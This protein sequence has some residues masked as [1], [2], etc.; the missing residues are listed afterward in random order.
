MHKKLFAVCLVAVIFVLVWSLSPVFAK[1]PDNNGQAGKEIPEQEGTYDVSG[2]PNLK[3][4]VFIH[5]PARGGRKPTPTPTPTPPP[6][7]STIC[8]LSDPDSTF[9]VGSTGWHLASG[10]WIYNL[11]PNSVPASV[12]PANLTTISTAAFNRWSGAIGNKVTFVQG[13]NTTINRAVYDGKN[14]ITW[15]RVSNSALAITYT[16]YYPS[17]GLVAEVDTIMNS[18][19]LWSWSNPASWTD[20]STTC[21]V[22]DSYDAQDILTHELGHWVGLDDY[23]TDPYINNTMY[24]YGSTTETKK[25]T[26]TTGDITG[27][28]AIY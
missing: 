9:V 21:A 16:W 20:P 24:G 1:N 6:S 11:N 2:H 17:T 22:V 10:S 13:P 3:V 4:R 28:A 5:R 8:G 14:I 15:G 27:A 26:L 12:G 25:D 23:Y 7:P 19:Y 18:P